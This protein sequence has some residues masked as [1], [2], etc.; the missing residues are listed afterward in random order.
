M[1][2]TAFVVSLGLWSI[3]AATPLRA[4]LSRARSAL[5]RLQ[6][7]G[8]EFQADRGAP[9]LASL[10]RELL[11]QVSALSAALTDVGEALARAGGPN[12]SERSV[13]Q[14][15]A[16]AMKKAT[17]EIPSWVRS[18]VDFANND[19]E[20]VKD[21]FKGELE[22]R[23][24][25]V[26]AA[27]R[28]LSEHWT[29]IQTRIDETKRWL[30]EGYVAALTIRDNAANPAEA[31]QKLEEQQLARLEVLKDRKQRTFNEWWRACTRVSESNRAENEAHRRWQEAMRSKDSVSTDQLQALFRNWK[32]AEEEKWNAARDHATATGEDRRLSEEITGFHNDLAQV[33]RDVRSFLKDANPEAI[34]K[35]VTEFETWQRLLENDLRR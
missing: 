13:L 25:T 14:R 7:L 24:Q 31:L 10:G 35:R 20:R 32:A 30:R 15:A 26:R 1:I 5:E 12:E 21:Y 27:T 11:D 18:A 33:M 3:V 23:S 4:Q 8:A 34:Q 29:S 22:G 19:T 16:L 28:Q 17:D 2:R 6:G 9:R